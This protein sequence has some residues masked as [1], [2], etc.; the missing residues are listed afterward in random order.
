MNDMTLES[1]RVKFGHAANKAAA[2]TNL[3]PLR[4]ISMVGAL[5]GENGLPDD[6]DAYR[7]VQTLNLLNKCHI[8]LHPTFEVDV[9]NIHPDHGRRDFMNETKPADVVVLCFIFNPRMCA[10][11]YMKDH[12]AKGLH[13][14]SKHHHEHGAWHDSALRVGAKII[15]VFGND[16]DTEV[17]PGVFQPD[18]QD[19]QFLRLKH[20]AALRY[21]DYAPHVLRH[22]RYA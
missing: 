10:G 5:P 15:T 3:P 22:R 12:A 7:L 9:V 17:G 6:V 1:L 19:S 20:P 18:A 21:D 16:G 8:P 2:D 11:Y 4:T 14:I 13:A